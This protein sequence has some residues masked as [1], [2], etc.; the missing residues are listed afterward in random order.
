MLFICLNNIVLKNLELSFELYMA[1]TPNIFTN[2][3]PETY[4]GS[5]DVKNFITDCRRFFTVSNTPEETR[6]IYVVAFLA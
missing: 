6:C 1:T 4:D 2:L 3:I 5:Q